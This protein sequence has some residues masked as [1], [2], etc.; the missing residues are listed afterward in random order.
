MT[1]CI[2]CKRSISVEHHFCPHCSAPQ[3]GC[4]N[5]RSAVRTG[6]GSQNVTVGHAPNANIYI[7]HA[8]NSHSQHISGL[9][10]DVALTNEQKTPIKA[11]WAYVAGWVGLLVSLGITLRYSSASAPANSAS[12]FLPIAMPIV[13]F[14]LGRYIIPWLWAIQKGHK[15]FLYNQLFRGVLTVNSSGF[16]TTH[17]VS[18]SCPVPSCNGELT[19][20]LLPI[21]KKGAHE[22]KLVCKRFYKDHHFPFYPGEVT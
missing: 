4:S 13:A 20:E 9:I 14:Y 3:N 22:Y 6:F 16:I 2:Q 21:G 1:N 12:F 8:G 17:A 15:L 11:V 18:G 10:P 7:G 5:H 19:V